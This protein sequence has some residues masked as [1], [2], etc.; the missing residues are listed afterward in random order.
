MYGLWPTF[1]PG[2]RNYPSYYWQGRGGH[3]MQPGAIKG[4]Q[5][6]EVEDR[7]REVGIPDDMIY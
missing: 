3:G 2:S 6:R 1:P 4:Y 7:W 5:Y